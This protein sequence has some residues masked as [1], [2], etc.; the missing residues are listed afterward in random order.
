MGPKG[1]GLVGMLSNLLPLVGPFI[2]RLF[3]GKGGFLGSMIARF[4]PK[5][6]LLKLGSAASG[7]AKLTSG[8]LKFL[9]NPVVLKILGMAG[10]VAGAAYG[11]WKIGKKLDSWLGIS[12]KFQ[13][14]VDAWDAKATQLANKVGAMSAKSL[15]KA[16]EG[17][18]EGMKG[19]QLLK[20]QTQVGA[21]K[22]RLED[23]GTFGRANQVAID[24]AQKKFMS[25]NIDKY[26]QYS[27]EYIST[28]RSR[29]LK[30]GGYGGKWAGS[31]AANYGRKR[32]K[33]FLEFLQKRGRK[34]SEGEQAKRYAAYQK[35]VEDVHGIKIS[36]QPKAKTF[37]DYKDIAIQTGVMVAEKVSGVYR[38]GKELAQDAAEEAM[39]H[40]RVITEEM[41]K[42][43][44]AALE[45][46]KGLAGT[47]AAGL[48]QSTNI[49]SSSVQNINTVNN[50]NT[51][52]GPRLSQQTRD[53]MQG[54][55]SE[56]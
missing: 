37:G 40:G 22:A 47:V 18:M 27:P 36:D 44:R 19:A 33:A 30:M 53:V 14:K 46:T 8:L 34:L 23:I 49:I 41:K 1:G 6:L 10:M 20:L 38:E 56:V 31:D 4:V 29:W 5:G 39:A 3:G 51:G 45:G 35:H 7:I 16:K 15:A 24:A 9:G 11:G 43:G 50:N 54:N 55:M 25:D 12:E 28:M 21:T 42:Q 2:G 26:M 13:A 52:S 17:G 32:E 48:Q